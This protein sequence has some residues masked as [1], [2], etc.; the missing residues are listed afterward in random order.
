MSLK[1]NLN[2]LIGF[3]NIKFKAKVIG[4][5]TPVN[6]FKPNLQR[7]VTGP[8]AVCSSNYD[9]ELS[10]CNQKIEQDN[11]QRYIWQASN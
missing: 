8:V 7:D 3:S 6:N 11:V 5:P 1:K 9:K 10:A 4:I 2:L